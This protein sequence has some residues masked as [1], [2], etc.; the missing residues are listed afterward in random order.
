MSNPLTSIFTGISKFIS[1]LVS[2]FKPNGTGKTDIK[3]PKRIS[4]S[5]K[6]P[7]F[8]VVPI[9]LVSFKENVARDPEDLERISTEISK[10]IKDGLARHYKNSNIFNIVEIYALSSVGMEFNNFFN[11]DDTLKDFQRI[12]AE[13]IWP[14]RA[15]ND[16][17][18]V[19]FFRRSLTYDPLCAKLLG[20]SLIVR[21][22]GIGGETVSSDPDLREGQSYQ[23]LVGEI[24]VRNS[25]GQ[26]I[27]KSPLRVWRQRADEHSYS[28]HIDFDVLSKAFEGKLHKMPLGI[29][30]S[31]TTIIEGNARKI[32]G[33]GMSVEEAKKW[34]SFLGG[35]IE[36]YVHT[37][38]GRKITS[39]NVNKLDDKLIPIELTEAEVVDA[40]T[41]TKVT[42]QLTIQAEAKDGKSYRYVFRFFDRA[43]KFDPKSNYLSL[44]G[45]L[46]REGKSEVVYTQPSL[47]LRAE[48]VFTIAEKPGSPG[49]FTVKSKDK[50]LTHRG[51]VLETEITPQQSVEV[52]F[53]DEISYTPAMTLEGDLSEFV[54]RISQ[55]AGLPQNVLAAEKYAGLIE[56]NPG[57]EARTSQLLK[58]H[59]ELGDGIFFT[60]DSGIG[61]SA[62]IF[63]RP[64]TQIMLK[65]PG[66]ENVWVVDRKNNQY[67]DGERVGETGFSVLLN[68]RYEIFVDRFR[69]ELNLST[70]PLTY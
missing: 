22:V 50:R 62:L 28:L 20:N 32:E 38:S 44:T 10:K 54:F 55:T 67:T 53:G 59:Y 30:F 3:T 8:I 69:L 17:R 65:A 70:T 35:F 61:R 4:A 13:Q 24:V 39:N 43:N 36:Y 58:D 6:F 66:R 63:D 45:Q 26:M 7:N 18:N 16:D 46:I 52:Q 23:F 19:Y 5:E 21:P 31:C 41:N 27:D 40:I 51:A 29:T 15:S 37:A 49:T 14:G 34:N 57:Y 56:I 60:K 47:N 64:Y 2:G 68:G 42:R 33:V 48:E 1:G 25:R 9:N 11:T 12:C